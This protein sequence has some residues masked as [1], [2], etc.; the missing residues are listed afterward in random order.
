[1][2]YSSLAGAQDGE[3][4]GLVFVGMSYIPVMLVA[5]ASAKHIGD[6]EIFQHGIMIGPCFNFLN[7]LV[8]PSGS[9]CVIR[10]NLHG[11]SCLISLCDYYCSQNAKGEWKK[12]HVV[13]TPFC[14]SY[15]VT[16]DKVE[17]PV[18]PRQKM[19][20]STSLSRITHTKIIP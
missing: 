1:M 12:I 19:A 17:V 5:F 8:M 3:N 4:N 11:K 18:Q 2:A 15:H 9:L 6:H 7:T 13:Q 14:F 16:Y 20:A 10:N